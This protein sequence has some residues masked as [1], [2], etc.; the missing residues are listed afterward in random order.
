VAVPS[1]ALKALKRIPSGGWIK[2]TTPF[3]QPT[4]TAVIVAVEGSPE[5]RVALSS[6]GRHEGSVEGNP[7]LVT[8]GK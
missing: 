7:E 8:G 5:L 4:E 2:V 1:K 3:D 6:R